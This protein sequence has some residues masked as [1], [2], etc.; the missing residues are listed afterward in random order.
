M[1][2]GKQSSWKMARNAEISRYRYVSQI[3]ANPFITQPNTSD[4]SKQNAGR[5]G[6]ARWFP[7]GGQVA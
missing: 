7:S 4:G 2:V 3:G 5:V 1:C 6:L